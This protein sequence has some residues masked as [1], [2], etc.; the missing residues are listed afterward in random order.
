MVKNDDILAR[1]F[2]FADQIVVW[3]DRELHALGAA[4]TIAVAVLCF[5]L[6]SA[7]DLFLYLGSH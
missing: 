7:L 3:F 6:Y 5:S 1:L 2:G 4:G